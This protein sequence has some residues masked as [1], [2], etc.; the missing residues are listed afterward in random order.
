MKTVIRAMFVV[1]L[2]LAGTQVPSQMIVPEVVAADPSSPLLVAKEQEVRAFF[3]QYVERY[4]KR[5]L[6]EFLS[7][8]SLRARQNQQDGLPEIRV[9][10][11]TLF[12][13]SRSLQLSLENMK[14]EIYQNAVEVRAHYSVNQVLKDGGA[15]KFWRG[16]A[17][18]ILGKEEE[19]LHILSVDYQ[20]S[21]PPTLAEEKIPEP[22]PLLAKE[23][24]VQQFFS[25]YVFQYNRRD[26]DGFLSFFSSKAVQNQ[27]DGLSEIRSI[28]TKF[29]DESRELRY[30]LEG[31]KT[32]IYQN[33]IEVKAHFRIDQMLKKPKQEKVWN[34]NIRW[35]LGR[36]GGALKIISLDYQ[37]EKS[38]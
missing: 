12:N 6:E 20:Y 35:V 38:P 1:F 23:E 4:N 19:K 27:R 17:R 21:V 8:F 15:K 33:R 2:C 9:I 16:D 10:Y 34:G 5:D 7:L 28:Y 25:N 22:L 26:I 30:A 11:S 13:R 24:E 29:F 3:S 31:M 32:E 14:I 37:N 18:W 36:E